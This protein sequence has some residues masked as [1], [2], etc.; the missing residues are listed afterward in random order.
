MIIYKHGRNGSESSFNSLFNVTI[1]SIADFTT[2]KR[3]FA[4]YPTSLIMNNILL[5]FVLKT[6][7]LFRVGS[8][9]THGHYSNFIERYL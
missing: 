5:I 1:A 7:K 3:S 9:T 4:L 8:N 2:Y 6:H